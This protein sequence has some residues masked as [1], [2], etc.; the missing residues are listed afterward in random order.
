MNTIEKMAPAGAP[1]TLNTGDTPTSLGISQ[2]SQR[3]LQIVALLVLLAALGALLWF[4]RR[5]ENANVESLLAQ[6]QD[7][8][9]VTVSA[10][11]GFYE[12]DLWVMVEQSDALPSDTMLYYSL[13]G[14][15]PTV[16]STPIIVGIYLPAVAGEVTVY[17][18]KIAVAYKGYCH[19]V[20]ERTYVVGEGASE[21]FNL[22]VI[23]L[24]CT[25]EALYNE[26]TGVFANYSERGDEWIAT[27]H[28]T[29]FD[30]DGSVLL[31]RGVGLGVSGNTSAADVVKSLRIEGG[32]EYDTSTD[33]QDKLSITLLTDES[34]ATTAPHVTEYNH[35]RLRSGSQDLYIG[36]NIRSSL[37]SRLA[38]ESG[39]DGCTATQRCIV[40]LNGAFYGIMDMQQP[41]SHS[42]LGDRYGLPDNDQIERIK[43]SEM[44]AR[45]LGYLDCFDTDLNDAANRAALEEAVDMDNFLLYYAIEILANNTDWPLNN[46][47]MWRYTGEAVDG[48]AYT[49]G[50]WRFLIFDSDLIYFSQM[51]ERFDTDF[52][53]GCLGDTFVNLM[54]NT[55]RG[56]GSVFAHVMESDEYRA[57]FLTLVCDLL[58]TSF[59]TDN[60]LEIAQQEYDKISA[61]YARQ[62]SEERLAEIDTAYD[63][64]VASVQ[65]REGLLREAFTS[66]FGVSE[67]YTVLVTADEGATVNWSN[68][69]ISGGE[70]YENEYYCGVP[71]TLTAEAQPGYTFVSWLVNGVAVYGDT[72][73]V[74]EAD[75]ADDGTLEIQAV[76]R[77]AD[78]GVLIL[79]EVSAAGNDDW[80]K[81]TNVG[82]KDIKLSDYYLSDDAAR[83]LAWQLPVVTL[84]PGESILINGKKNKHALGE[85]ICS[86]NLK[87]G[88]TLYLS[89]RDGNVQDRIA[90]P[91]MSVSETYGRDENGSLVFFDNR[92]GSRRTA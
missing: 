23:S 86:F 85:Y 18:V 80:F 89:D 46:F 62:L 4:C 78:R 35:I 88:E 72:L 1:E 11:S 10:E 59:D 29:L 20:A 57:R 92:D 68:H 66:Y 5:R 51:P 58:N 40:Y 49:D 82:T 24:T 91:S 45:N 17:P 2:K 26:E 19:T 43:G 7:I 37:M 76:C 36:C 21:R 53:E 63:A 65:E 30:T 48:N 28:M 67:T 32:E 8:D 61:E 38:E 90:I 44:S 87:C 31:D 71:L 16:E 13:D 22:P 79:S 84:A 50:R 41:Y 77:R 34:A 25:N 74:T 39:F 81:L 69:C 54:E 47:E 56:A 83:P 9:I 42:F 14:E 15:D 64:L 3:R 12:D 33:P 73:T 52:F 55:S 60:V 75:R 70:S 6:Y 27:S